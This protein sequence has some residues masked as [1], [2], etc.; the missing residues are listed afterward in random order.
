MLH[1][2]AVSMV[3]VGLILTVL[4]MSL[5]I[6]FISFVYKPVIES[7]IEREVC[8]D[9]VLLKAKTKTLGIAPSINLKCNTT[10]INI[11]S[12]D[13]LNTKGNELIANSMYDCWNQFGEGEVD[14]L[15]KWDFGGT[16]TF[17]FLC[18]KIEFDSSIKGNK[19]DLGTYLNE[20]KIPLQD[21]TYV[22]YFTKVKDAKLNLDFLDKL[23]T[24]EPLYILF[25]ADKK[26]DTKTLTDYNLEYGAIG[27]VS[28]VAGAK[29]GGA[30]GALFGGFGAIPTAVAGCA[31]GM[32]VSSVAVISLEKLKY[33]PGLY[34]T[35]SSDVVKL[36][37]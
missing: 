32:L 25:F 21:E 16:D 12:L 37:S 5:L 22:E 2:K 6:Y 36:C 17:C 33:V 35:D 4:V 28:C 13:Q 8:K 10:S 26:F 30:L 7:S 20:N 23:K 19:F 27:G 1:K 3:L 18:S 14:F 15:S 34:I 29:I 24:D 9:S 31:G 11:D